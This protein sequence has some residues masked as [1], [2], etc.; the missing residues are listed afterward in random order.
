MGAAGWALAA[1]GDGQSVALALWV[2]D[3]EG[4][5]AHQRGLLLA[6]AAG[7]DRVEQLSHLAGDTRPSGAGALHQLAHARLADA[8]ALG[9]LGAR[10]PLQVAERGGFALAGGEAR[11]QSL[12]DMAQAR[13]VVEL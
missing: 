5:G 13:T 8:H 1:V 7:L 4:V 6:P 10:E 9:R 3:A 11:A 2:E 12:E